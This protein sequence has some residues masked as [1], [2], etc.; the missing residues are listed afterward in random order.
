MR[1]SI[2]D[3]H[4]IDRVRSRWEEKLYEPTPWEDRG[5]L[6]LKRE[7]YFA[8]LG[9]GGINGSKLRQCIW[10][11]QRA[12]AAGAPG[13][14]SGAS[15]KSPQLSMGTAVALHYGMQSVHVMGATKAY[16]AM[17]HPNVEVAAWL[18]ARFRLLRVGYNPVL[19]AE[20]GRLLKGSL[21]GWYHLRYGISVEHEEADEE[22]AVEVEGFHRL[23]SEQVRNIPPGVETLLMPAGSCNSCVSVLYGLARFRPTTLKQVVLFGI[24]PTRLR[25][26]DDRLRLIE[27]V[28]GQ[29]GLVR[30]LFTYD[31]RQDP[32]LGKEFNARP[33]F[34]RPYMLT[35]HDLHAQK[36]ASYQDEMPYARE[37]VHFHPTYEGKIMTYMDRNPG[38]FSRVWRPGSRCGFWIVGSRPLPSAMLP[39]LLS[40]GERPASLPLYEEVL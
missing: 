17:A 14:L 2:F 20:V 36:F 24:G 30:S 21:R 35:H 4:S 26:I 10:L 9:Y 6:L 12:A 37:G 39:T 22:A 16:T 40:V 31:F 38:E 1:D 11:M 8:P 27:R 18:G 23:G 34:D 7:D 19:Q 25:W 5:G 28:T 15:V 13:I 33:S 3:V 32:E 29:P